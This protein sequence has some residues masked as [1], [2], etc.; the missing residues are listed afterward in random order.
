M[1]REA[2]SATMRAAWP[3]VRRSAAGLIVA[4]LV[5][6][7]GVLFLGWDL[8]VLLVAY[9]IESGVVGV[10]SVAKILRAEGEDDPDELPSIEFNDR[11]AE[12]FV[13]RSNRAIA[14]FFAFHY[15]VFWVVHGVFVLLF[16][17]IFAGM[18][19][20]APSVVAIAAASL[21]AYH[22]VSYRVNYLGERE[23]EGTGPVTLMVEPYRRVFV[24]H[25]TVLFGAFAV[26]AVGAPIGALVVMIL[27]KTV[28]D[29]WGHWKE[30]E[31]ARDRVPDPATTG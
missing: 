26:A 23:Y 20:A 15:G 22:A 24:L 29:L 8:H 21:A 6:L 25:L 14:V 17:G 30:H 12:S 28:L 18:D 27:V 9:W 7:A 19:A 3:S 5:P 16:P 1:R 13:G 10:E 4:N 11:S 2:A 31:R